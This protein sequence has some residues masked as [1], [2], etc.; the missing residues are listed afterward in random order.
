[1]RTTVLALKALLPGALTATLGTGRNC[2]VIRYLE[3]QLPFALIRRA[4]RALAAVAP[5]GSLGG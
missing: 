2:W 1:M 4:A 5:Q 3:Q